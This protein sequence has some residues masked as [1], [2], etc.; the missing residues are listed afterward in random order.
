[1]KTIFAIILFP[2]FSYQCLAQGLKFNG[3]NAPIELRTSY[4]V[5]SKV[6]IRVTKEISINF[7]TAINQAKSFGNILRIHLEKQ[8]LTYNLIYRQDD[9]GIQEF[10]LNEEGKDNLITIRLT[11]NSLRHGKWFDVKLAFNSQGKSVTLGI[12]DKRQSRQISHLPVEFFPDIHFGKSDYVVDVPDFSIKDLTVSTGV[13]KYAFPLNESKGSDVHDVSGKVMGKVTEPIWLINDA[14]HWKKI[15]SLSSK[16]I[17]GSNFDV[18]QQQIL[19]FNQDTLTLFDLLSRTLRKTSYKNPLPVKIQLGNSFLYQNR[20]YVYEV[21]NL[22]RNACTMASVDLNDFSSKSVSRS[23][24]VM[25]L[26]HHTGFVDEQR[27]RYIITGGFGNQRYSNKVLA[28]D[29]KAG[30]WDTLAISGSK[31]EPRYFTSSFYNTKQDNLYIYGGM[32]NESGDHTIGRRYYYDL[33][34]LNLNTLKMRKNWEIK[35]PEGNMVPVRNLVTNSNKYFYMLCYPEY[36]PNSK[37]Q[38]YRVGIADGSAVKMGDQIP[39]LSEKIKTNANL[40]L[41]E[42]LNELY[43][44]VQ[45]FDKEEVR[46][47]FTIYALSF[48]PIQKTQLDLYP[49]T[50]SSGNDLIYIFG[51]IILLVSSGAYY[52]FAY[53]RKPG[54]LSNKPTSLG[55]GKTGSTVVLEDKVAAEENPNAIFIFGIFRINDRNGVDISHQF[56]TKIKQAFLLILLNTPKNGISSQQLSEAL[57]PEKEHLQ[58]KNIRGVTINQLRKTL[59]NLDGIE[60]IYEKG[61]FKLLFDKDYFCDFLMFLNLLKKEEYTL[62]VLCTLLERGKFLL[63]LNYPMFDLMK[64]KTEKQILTELYKALETRYLQ[65]EFEITLRMAKICLISDP[66][67]EIALYYLIASLEKLGLKDDAK[68]QYLSFTKEYARVMNEQYSNTYSALLNDRPNGY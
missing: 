31:I 56:G 38:L 33:H 30:V 26:H 9:Q 17:A 36:L 58:T 13:Q 53:K 48:P 59:S 49:I 27:N 34:T 23:T 12:L 28:F 32:G 67:S 4:A 54:N 37:L 60:L 68:R 65:S 24:V 41:N 45:E 10:K 46:S 39:I 40:F 7:K 16:T 63:H 55:K 2:F 6:Q 18:K 57:W 15:L 5:F 1:M 3:N 52:F 11:K 21:N 20:L 25:Q 19:L 66:L 29:L 50:S 35:W 61:V 14:Y 43:C 62:D 64:E 47:K 8:N 51:A 42:E 44:I 22:P